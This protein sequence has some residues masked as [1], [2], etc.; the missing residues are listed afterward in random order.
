MSGYNG[1]NS[2]YVATSASVGQ[3]PDLVVLSGAGFSV[4]VTNVSGSAP[5]FWTVS[6]QGGTCPVPSSAG[7]VSGTYV[8][9]GAAGTSTSARHAGQFG[10]IV[11]VISTGTPSYMVEVQGNHSNS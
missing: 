4:K 7:S 6:H 10:S 5:L 1:V 8:T 11:Q 2:V 9:A 3:T